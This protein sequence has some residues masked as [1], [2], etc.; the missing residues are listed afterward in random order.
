[1]VLVS[2]TFY[3]GLLSRTLHGLDAYNDVWL[4][5]RK[6]NDRVS[7]LHSASKHSQKSKRRTFIPPKPLLSNRFCAPVRSL[8]ET[9]SCTKA[10]TLA[11]STY[12]NQ[13]G[14]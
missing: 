12:R 10:F 11:I 5:M 2:V 14:S 13:A 8:G 7:I 9:V 3:T 6:K 4:T 1:M